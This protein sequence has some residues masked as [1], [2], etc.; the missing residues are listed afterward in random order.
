MKSSKE[1]TKAKTSRWCEHSEKAV[2]NRAASSDKNWKE[3]VEDGIK[4]FFYVQ[5]FRLNSLVSSC[6]SVIYFGM[7]DWQEDFV[8]TERVTKK[9]AEHTRHW[10][11]QNSVEQSA[12]QPKKAAVVHLLLSSQKGA[13]RAPSLDSGHFRRAGTVSQLHHNTLPKVIIQKHADYYN[14][15]AFCTKKQFQKKHTM[16]FQVNLGG[17][18]I[19]CTKMHA[20][21]PSRYLLLHRSDISPKALV[22]NDRWRCWK[23]QQAESK[24][25][26]QRRRGIIDWYRLGLGKSCFRR[27]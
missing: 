17:S 22:S 1:L 5:L 6:V 10:G 8:K 24:E 25:K 13:D 12:L 2:T 19:C 26:K 21:K 18:R 3:V 14:F 11:G 15:T 7:E 27:W 4:L 23:Q 9:F 16:Y 20:G